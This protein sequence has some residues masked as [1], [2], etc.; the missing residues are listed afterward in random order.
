MILGRGRGVGGGG[1]LVCEFVEGVGAGRA[2]RHLETRLAV[3]VVLFGEFVGI[4]HWGLVGFV[5]GFKFFGVGV[6]ENYLKK[7]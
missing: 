3:E 7:L 2:G 1:G 4:V 5:S 6:C